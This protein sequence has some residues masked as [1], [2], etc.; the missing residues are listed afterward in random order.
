VLGVVALAHGDQNTAADQFRVASGFAS[1]DESAP[2]H[3]ANCWWGLGCVS[4]T[5]GRIPDA[6]RL[7]HDALA[8]RHRIGDHLGVA[9]SLMGQRPSSRAPI[10]LRP[11]TCRRR[12]EVADQVGRCGDTAPG[13]R[14]R[15]RPGT[16]GQAQRGARI[17]GVRV[18][19]TRSNP[20]N[21][22]ARRDQELERHA[23]RVTRK[24][25]TWAGWR[26]TLR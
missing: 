13:R 21:A 4:R 6:A 10:G 1:A 19:S 16:P 9:E 12:S 22:C 18:R 5:A 17:P 23:D 2:R 24:D 8:L 7:H 25:D 14:R 26:V 11:V 15:S 3:L 20:C